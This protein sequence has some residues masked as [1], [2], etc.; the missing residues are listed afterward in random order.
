MIRGL[1][2]T[3]LH[4]MATLVATLPK[5]PALDTA[6]VTQDFYESRAL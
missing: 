2:I 5:L 6:L 3:L 1:I 4:K